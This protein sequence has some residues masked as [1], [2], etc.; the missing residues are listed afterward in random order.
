MELINT[1]H[2]Y[3][4]D[5][6]QTTNKER[7]KKGKGVKAVFLLPLDA[8]TPLNSCTTSMKILQRYLIY[9]KTYHLCSSPPNEDQN[10]QEILL[11]L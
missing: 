7:H 8:P 1:K 5:R 6:E 11:S 10:H 2:L 4:I 9:Y 3:Y